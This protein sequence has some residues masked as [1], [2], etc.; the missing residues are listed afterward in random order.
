MLFPLP[1]GLITWFHNYSTCQN[2]HPREIG[3][4]PTANLGDIR[5]NTERLEETKISHMHFVLLPL[6][7]FVTVCH[8]DCLSV[9]LSLSLFSCL[10]KG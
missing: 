10:S 1:G 8:L 7:I 9:C 3:R 4:L 6:H 5:G 2:N